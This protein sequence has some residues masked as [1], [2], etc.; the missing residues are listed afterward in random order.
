MHVV[1][2]RSESAFLVLLLAGHTLKPLDRIVCARRALAQSS[3]PYSLSASHT[4]IQ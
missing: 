2:L 1:I 3:I 4:L